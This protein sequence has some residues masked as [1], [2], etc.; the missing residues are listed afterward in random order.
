MRA[1]AQSSGNQPKVQQS[2]GAQLPVTSRCYQVLHTGP[3]IFQN[4]G[5][6]NFTVEEEREE[7]AAASV[8]ARGE[9]VAWRLRRLVCN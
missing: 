1:K 3:L 6:V 2:V 8:A 5:E 9:I 7:K 4:A